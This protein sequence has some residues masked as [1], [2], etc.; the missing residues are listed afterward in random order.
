MPPYTFEKKGDTKLGGVVSFDFS[1]EPLGG[2]TYRVMETP[3]CS[4]EQRIILV[5]KKQTRGALVALVEL[6]IFG[7]GLADWVIADTVA[8]NSKEEIDKGYVP[9]G[10]FKRCGRPSPLRSGKII[11]QIPLTSTV[12]EMS[13]DVYGILDLKKIISSHPNSEVNIFVKKK[14]RVYYLTSLSFNG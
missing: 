1:L 7:L 3:I 8:Q 14:D 12:M 10:R 5:K 13:T 9:S 11:V 6:P 4:I 2:Y